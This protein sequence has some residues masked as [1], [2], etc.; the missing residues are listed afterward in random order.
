MHYYGM[1]WISCVVKFFVRI[2]ASPV[3]GSLAAALHSAHAHYTYLLGCDLHRRGYSR[4]TFVI[5]TELKIQSMEKRL[6]FN[7]SYLAGLSIF[8][9][10]VPE[11]LSEGS[12]ICAFRFIL[13]P[14]RANNVP[15]WIPIGRNRVHRH[16]MHDEEC[17]QEQSIP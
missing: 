4:R 6:L 14:L 9:S 1:E 17:C 11:F 7:G 10:K 15:K 12:H 5:K 2:Q 16:S 8:S 13:H 3:E